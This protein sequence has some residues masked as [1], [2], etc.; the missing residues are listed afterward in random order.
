MPCTRTKAGHKVLA[1]R[2]IASAVVAGA[3]LAGAHG[4]ADPLIKSQ[5]EPAQ[6]QEI[7]QVRRQTKHRSS[8][9][10]TMRSQV[11]EIPQRFL[12]CWSGAVSEAQLTK[13]ELLSPPRIDVWLT[14]NYR[15][16][17]VR[18]G[19]ELKVTI[20][21]SGVDHH[22]QVLRATSSLEPTRAGGNQVELGGWL[23]LI[24]RTSDT[25]GVSAG[26]PAVVV[27]QVK[28]QGELREDNAMTVRG[29]VMGY[30][31]GRPWWVG[32]WNCNF[33]RQH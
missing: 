27:E 30:Y 8:H 16:C 15:V 17:F 19:A 32:Q 25:F 6:T 13:L 33:E 5:S 1:A 14:K 20:A 9:G 11:V 10:K 26:P 29:E 4:W 28:L 22:G 3:V 18:Q 21:D 2:A 24:E 23:T 7:P 12:G 31:N